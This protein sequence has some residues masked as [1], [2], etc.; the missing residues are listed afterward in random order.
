MCIRDSTWSMTTKVV[1]WLYTAVIRPMFCYA[2]VIWWSR[3]NYKTVGKKLEHLQRLACLY[4]SG[5]V[6]TTPT[7][8]LEI[9]LGITQ[10][11]VY[12]KQDA[13]AACNRLKLAAQWVFTNLATHWSIY[14]CL[15]SYPFLGWGATRYQ[16]RLYLETTIRLKLPPGRNGR[17]T[18]L[19]FMT[20]LCVSLTAQGALSTLGLV[21]TCDSVAIAR[22]CYGNS[23]CPSVTLVDQPKTVEARITQFSPYSSPIPLVFRG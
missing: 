19:G 4:I 14:I 12:V 6:R 8:A 11:S 13:M 1:Y 18:Q 20:M 7:A 21:F 3:T 16:Q 15:T 2:A 23:V 9:V 10:L 5:A 22:I 17:T